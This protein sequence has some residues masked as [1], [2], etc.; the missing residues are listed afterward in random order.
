M[1]RLSKPRPDWRQDAAPL[2]SCLQVP[3]PVAPDMHAEGISFCSHGVSIS[4][5]GS[6]ASPVAAPSATLPNHFGRG[7][8]EAYARLLRAHPCRGLPPPLRPPVIARSWSRSRYET[9]S[10]ASHG[11]IA[12]GWFSRYC[13]C[14]APDARLCSE[15]VSRN[16][17][18]PASDARH[19]DVPCSYLAAVFSR[20]RSHCLYFSISSESDCSRSWPF[21]SLV[22]TFPRPR[23]HRGQARAPCKD[24]RTRTPEASFHR[25]GFA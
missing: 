18:S 19:L 4:A 11:T 5:D 1:Y 17:Q 2:A 14:R 3:P 21:A 6:L 7:G 10:V 16:V 13:G 23:S 12:R 15:G 9:V 20:S 8:C 22:M 25:G 24:R